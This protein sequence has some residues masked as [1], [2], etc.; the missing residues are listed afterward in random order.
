MRALVCNA[1]GTIDDLILT[2][3]PDPVPGPGEVLI[4]V[5]ATSV[6]FADTL[7]VAGRYQ[8]KPDFPFSPGLEA[9]GRVAAVAISPAVAA[10]GLVADRAV[11]GRGRGGVFR[12][13]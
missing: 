12:R 9:A 10:V 5:A 1:W 7:M 6:N 11:G 8:T 13:D 4:D 3:V 2:D